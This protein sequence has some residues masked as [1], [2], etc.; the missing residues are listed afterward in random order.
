M[1]HN[2]SASASSK[3]NGSGSDSAGR[4]TTLGV[5]LA[6]ALG[7]SAPGCAH[8]PPI[9]AHPP[10]LHAYPPWYQVLSA[11]SRFVLVMDNKA[12]LDTETG[13]VWERIAGDTNGDGQITM[14]PHTGPEDRLSWMDAR[15][16]CAARE[17]GGRKGWRLPAFNELASLVDLSPGH[18]APK[19]PD[20]HPFTVIGVTYWAA[21]TSATHP[22]RVWAVDFSNGNV[23]AGRRD[24]HPL[25]VWCVRGGIRGPDVY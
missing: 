4:V 23:G 10:P 12:V 17:V 1:S 11:Q 18:G 21:T 22:G 15:E 3:S 9:H 25:F 13:L 14:P 20:G 19:L 6:L 7:M 24:V 16:Y 2:S 5:L 8:R